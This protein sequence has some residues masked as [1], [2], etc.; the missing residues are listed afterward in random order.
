MDRIN[1]VFRLVWLPFLVTEMGITL[2]RL[3]VVANGGMP[4]YTGY[5]TASKRAYDIL[6]L[7]YPKHTGLAETTQLPFLG[8]VL[9]HHYSIGDL[10]IYSGL[11]LLLCF[12]FRELIRSKFQLLTAGHGK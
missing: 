7:P 3:V 4:A 1:T 6:N 10:L 9:I 12:V 2:N 5:A 8:D 11:M